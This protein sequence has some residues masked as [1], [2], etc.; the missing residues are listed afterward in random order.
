MPDIHVPQ[1]DGHGGGK[2]F[3]KIVLE[4]VLIGVG[5]FLGLAGEQWRGNVRHREMAEQALRR[6]R[7]EL[8]ANRKSVVDVKDYHVDRLKE[9]NTYFALAPAKRETEGH[10]HLTRSIAP[11]FL[12]HSAWDLALATQSLSYV[13]TDLG[14]SLSSIYNV[15]AAVVSESQGF[16][17]GMFVRPPSEDLTAFLAGAQAYFGDATFFESRLMTMYDDILPR[18]ARALNEK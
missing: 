5:V 1:L 13:D 10:L 9:L 8:V 15:Q 7:T 17:Q 3:I 11:A 14:V 2:S 16:T 4:V 12:E 18:I 6:F